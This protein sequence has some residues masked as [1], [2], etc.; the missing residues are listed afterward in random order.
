MAR[1]TL[2]GGF[3][4]AMKERL[5]PHGFLSGNGY[6]VRIVPDVAMLT[7][8]LDIKPRKGMDIMIGIIPCCTGI[9]AGYQ[10][11]GIPVTG[12]FP[13]DESW[14]DLYELPRQTLLPILLKMF[15]EKAYKP[16][17]TMSTVEELY[18]FEQKCPCI[19]WDPFWYLECAQMGRYEQV[20]HHLQ[21]YIDWQ[22]SFLLR[23]KN[24]LE[25]DKERL[26]ETKHAG[27]KRVWKRIVESR[28]ED[29]LVRERDLAFHKEIIEQVIR[30]DTTG[31]DN[32]VRENLKKSR[33][34]FEQYEGN[35]RV[36][37]T[38]DF[39]NNHRQAGTHGDGP[40]GIN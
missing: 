37:G 22:S 34:F 7:V 11:A 28:N 1:E 21:T 35:N 25:D 17:I 24:N 20:I 2:Q 18:E 9:S 15:D 26:E 36:F 16:L 5:F 10:Y 3:E 13:V 14:L 19:V 29:I 30:G 33:V 32:I 31:I 23:D 39:W 38:M 12:I 8:V 27:S 4:K 40:N 6:F